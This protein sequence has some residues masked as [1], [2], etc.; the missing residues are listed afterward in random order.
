[1]RKTLTLNGRR[2]AAGIDINP[3]GVRVVVMSRWLAGPAGPCVEHIGIAPLPLEAMAGPELLDPPAVSDAIIQALGTFYTPRSAASLRVAMAIAPSAT[4]VTTV[5]RAQLE[6]VH[7]RRPELSAA[8]L[9]SQSVACGTPAAMLDPMALDELEPA[10]RAHAEALLGVERSTLAVDWFA[11]RSPLAMPDH[12]TIAAAARDH[13]DARID[14][15]AGAGLQL[16][17]ID[18]E[19]VA[20]LRACR[21]DATR[22]IEPDEMYAVLWLGDDSTHLWAI[23]RGRPVRE[24]RLLVQPDMPASLLASLAM[25]AKSLVGEQASAASPAA[26]PTGCAPL[27]PVLDGILVAG[28]FERLLEA[29]ITLDDISAALG[30]AAFEFDAAC[31]CEGRAAVALPALRPAALAVAYGLALRGVLQ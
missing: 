6:P 28:D 25:F 30:C 27:P 20:A 5:P 18:A 16:V 29:G 19:P 17:A 24:L 23:Y 10:V 12:L 9:A 15:A 4:L 14:A 26:C 21:Y 13:I 31:Q 1:M 8:V 3:K 7:G 2:F 11:S 22:E